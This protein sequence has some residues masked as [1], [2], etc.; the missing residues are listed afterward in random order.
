MNLKKMFVCAMGVAALG[1]GSCNSDEPGAG[2]NPSEESKGDLYAR[3]QLYLPGASRSATD[4]FDGNTNSD[5]GFEIG[6]T[7]E[8][9]VNNV[10]VVLATKADGADVFTPVAVSTSSA[11][12]AA[13]FD[14]KAPVF[15]IMFRQDD[16]RQSAGQD[17]YI[18][19]YCNADGLFDIDTDF[20]ASDFVDKVAVIASDAV[21]QGI[22]EHGN[23]LMAN[24]PNIAIPSKKLPVEDELTTAYNTPA[25]ALDLG[26]V[27]VARVCSRFDFKQVNGNVYPVYDV[28]PDEDGN[29]VHIAD[30][31]LLAMSSVNIAKEFYY[32]PRVSDDGTD[33]GWKLCG[34]EHR[35]NWVVSPNWDDKSADRL[36][37]GILAKYFR[38]SP[39][40]S[41]EAYDYTQLD[42]FNG[43][44]DD[45]QNWDG[46]EGFDKTGYKIWR[47][48]TENTLPEIA[49]QKKGV[50]TG[51]VFKAEICNPSEP[52]LAAAMNA[53]KAVYSY[54]G[55]IYGDVVAL[56][57]VAASVSESNPLYKAYARVFGENQLKKDENSDFV[58]ADA[59]LTDCTAAANNGTFKIYRPD[60]AGRYCVYYLYRNRHNDNGNNN[61]MGAMEFGTVR[62]NIYK[63]AVNSI[64]DFG[65][66]AD[67][68]DDDDPEDPDDPDEDPKTYLKV[69]CRVVPWMVR[70]NNIEF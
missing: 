63:L 27:D 28:N 23:F 19:A 37:A 65:H 14:E 47:Y 12:P 17:V 59:D 24:A 5:A 52:A 51:V 38:Q 61:V 11:V 20:T 48:V 45:D 30:V 8:N 56:R 25:K 7:Y 40:G 1:L 41:Y 29:Q 21:N 68:D 4:D 62:N 42:T 44:D 53:G 18:F 55:T 70:I 16:I 69:S 2:K 67:P 15:N 66:T 31:K 33:N 26:T 35:N 64:T 36:G 32:L 54:N 60:G 46:G 34:T 10:T 39:A 58:V 57:K 22:W 9:T 13:G 49:S 43:E 50:S 6:K 3:I